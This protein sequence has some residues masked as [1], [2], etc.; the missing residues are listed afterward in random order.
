MER[1]T[2]RTTMFRHAFC[3]HSVVDLASNQAERGF[4]GVATPSSSLLIDSFNSFKQLSG[5]APIHFSVRHFSYLVDAHTTLPACI[6]SLLASSWSLFRKHQLERQSKTKK[7]FVFP[8]YQF[9]D[10]AYIPVLI[11]S[12]FTLFRLFLSTFPPTASC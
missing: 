4:P 8:E 9:L 11:Q 7:D 6:S 3:K 10:I 5:A 12:P 1:E 2:C